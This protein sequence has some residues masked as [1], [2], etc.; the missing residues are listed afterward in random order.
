MK[1]QIVLLSSAALLTFAIAFNGCKKDDTTSPVISLSGNSSVDVPLNSTY[2]DA[3]ATANDDKDGTITVTSDA[4]STNPNVNKAGT[5]TINY[6]ATDAAGNVA[7][8]TRTVRVYNE[9]E[10]FAGTYAHCADTCQSTPPASFTATVTSS[11]TLNR[12]IKI[13]NFGAFGSTVSVYAT[14]T[15]NTAL[16]TIDC[17]TGQS[18]GG[19]AQINLSYPANS[20]VISP[21]ASST[22]FRIQ[23]GWTDGTTS[24][25]CTG[26]YIR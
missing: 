1:K 8:A 2:T 13:E 12:L 18:L 26:T 17:P 24:D 6:S 16:A 5:Y 10:A 11:D 14:I 19:A 22:A 23:Y 4:S 21:A 7:T 9:A 15:A 20:F 25:V 3:G